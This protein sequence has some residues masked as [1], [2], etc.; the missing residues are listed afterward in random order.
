MIL[1]NSLSATLAIV[2]ILAMCVQWVCYFQIVVV[3]HSWQY[4]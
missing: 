1:L 4:H 2:I 3:E